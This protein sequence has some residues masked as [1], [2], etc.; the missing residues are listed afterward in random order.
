[1][2]SQASVSGWA[3]LANNPRRQIFCQA[4]AGLYCLLYHPL[5]PLLRL[6]SPLRPSR[7]RRAQANCTALLIDGFPAPQP[8]VR[9]RLANH[10][11]YLFLHKLPG[12]SLDYWLRQGLDGRDPATLALRRNLLREL[13]AFVGRLH[14][15]GYLHGNLSAKNILTTFRG[16]QFGFALLDNADVQ[17]HQTVPG[18]GLLGDLLRLDRFEAGT[19]TRTDRWRFFLAIR[20]YFFLFR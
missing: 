12:D 18:T 19:L 14:A 6:L 10:S 17:L 13:G 11:E 15:G 1:M 20:S 4:K 9:G 7:A 5:P 8:I 2:A 3:S 16:G